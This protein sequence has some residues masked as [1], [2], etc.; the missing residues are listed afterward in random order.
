[1]PRTVKLPEST[2]LLLRQLAVQDNRHVGALLRDAIELYL[3][4]RGAELDAGAP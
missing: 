1:V 4:S 2:D 3:S